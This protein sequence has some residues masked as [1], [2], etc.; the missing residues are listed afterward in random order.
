MKVDIF[1][2]IYSFLWKWNKNNF[3]SMLAV[4]SYGKLVYYI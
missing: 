4:L 2:M 3:I 1:C